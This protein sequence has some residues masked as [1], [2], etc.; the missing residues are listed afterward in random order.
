[1]MAMNVISWPIDAIVELS[2][3]VKICKYTWLYFD[4]HGGA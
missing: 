3:I 1:M 4:G 2:V